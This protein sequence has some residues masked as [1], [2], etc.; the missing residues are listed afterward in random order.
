MTL[1]APRKQIFLLRFFCFHALGVDGN[2]FSSAG[3]AW[4][5][6]HRDN[7]ENVV[8][9]LDLTEIARRH[10][11]RYVQRKESHVDGISWFLRFSFIYSAGLVE[12]WMNIAHKP[13][14]KIMSISTCFKRSVF[15]YAYFVTSSLAWTNERS[16]S[17][18]M[19][20]CMR[21][22]QHEDLWFLK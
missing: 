8:S 15:V 18:A 9:R 6:L 19:L 21:L 4:A 7:V 17:R 11:L 14:L 22:M 16:S 10:V 5:I 20:S 1:P 2:I 13:Q 3:N 12:L